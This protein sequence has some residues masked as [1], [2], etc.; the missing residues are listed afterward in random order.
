VELL[1][2]ALRRRVKLLRL[3]LLRRLGL[4]GVLNVRRM[5]DLEVVMARRGGRGGGCCGGSGGRLVASGGGLEDVFESLARRLF[6]LRLLLRRWR[7]QL[8]LL[9]LIGSRLEVVERG[10]RVAG[11]EMLVLQLELLVRLE[12]DWRLLLLLLLLLLRGRL[13]L[14]LLLLLL[15]G[16]EAGRSRSRRGVYRNGL[17]RRDGGGSD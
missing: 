6:A 10:V 12:D 14:L 1:L 7:L 8:L 13:L 15:P 17:G 3:V 2:R 11:V 5:L 9:L 4:V 16:R